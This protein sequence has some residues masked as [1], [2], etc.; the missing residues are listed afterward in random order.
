MQTFWDG[1]EPRFP[2]RA[3]HGASQLAGVRYLAVVYE[4]G[5][6]LRVKALDDGGQRA[7]R[8][9][10]ARTY[11]LRAHALVAPPDALADDLATLRL[12][13]RGVVEDELAED[14]GPAVRTI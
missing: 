13:G 11:A 3:V 14:V 6:A 5:V 2:H 10:V 9:I 12:G 7:R 8:R 4:T 1:L